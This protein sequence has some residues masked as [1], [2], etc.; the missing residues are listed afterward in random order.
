MKRCEEQVWD[1]G[2]MTDCGRNLPC[3]VH[4]EEENRAKR[5]IEEIHRRLDRRYE[6]GEKPTDRL[7]DVSKIAREALK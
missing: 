7:K 5:A 1:N 6:L 4:P 3:P 2:D